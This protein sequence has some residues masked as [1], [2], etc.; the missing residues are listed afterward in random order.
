M[1]PLGA[2]SFAAL[3]DGLGPFEPRPWIGVAVS[4]G[5][6]S[7]AAALLVRDWARGRGGEVTG[8]V[9]DHRLRPESTAEAELTQ[10]RLRQAG[11][12]SARLPLIGLEPGPGLSVRARAAR[13]AALESAC[14]DR[15]ILH[16]V[17]GHHAADQAETIAM[18]LLAR[19]HA[20]GLAGMA[21]VVETGRLRKLRPLLTTPPG[22]LRALLRAAGLDWVEDPSN[23]DPKYLRARL[24]R[25]RA[26]P[27]G[28]GLATRA[29][30]A[31]SSARAVARAARER[32]AA[33]ALAR[34]VRIHPLGYA[35]LSGPIPPDALA[36]LLGMLAGAERPPPLEQVAELAAHPRAATLGGV[37]LLPA[38]RLGPGFLLV[39]EEAAMQGWI[40][41]D[42]GAL[43]DGRFRLTRTIPDA[44]LGP[45][46]ADG[47][48][49]RPR[50]LPDAVLRTLPVFRRNGRV[51]DDAASLVPD[52]VFSPRSCAFGAVFA[53]PLPIS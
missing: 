33:A 17:F 20:P 26:D 38:G 43:W 4:G 3:M 24:R 41:A 28:D 7:L 44:T 12:L 53:A 52:L 40:P 23:A 18:R 32:Q 1:T 30:L 10:A 51:I 46:G 50:T 8:L 9:V 6:D 25:L 42:A 45:R 13:H 19:S 37:R 47:G 31:S 49:D 2:D 14:A 34:A 15:G 11:I 27:D 39:R 36:A 29:L 35:V 16:L 48:R 21:S 5:A 22:R